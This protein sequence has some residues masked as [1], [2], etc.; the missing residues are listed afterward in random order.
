[1]L[2][3]LI[4]IASLMFTQTSYPTLDVPKDPDAR[5]EV[6]RLT[7]LADGTRE[8]ITR[9]I[10]RRGQTFVRRHIWCDRG[11]YRVMGEGHTIEEMNNARPAWNSRAYYDDTIAGVIAAYACQ[12]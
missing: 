9:R 6:L 8:I 5:Y 1:M 12:S 7:T 4:M 2:A 10:G 11:I 3:S